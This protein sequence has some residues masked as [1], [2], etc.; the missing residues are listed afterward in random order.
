M[1]IAMKN[2]VRNP[3]FEFPLH[4]NFHL[5]RLCGTASCLLSEGVPAV[6]DFN[7]IPGAL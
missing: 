1:V 4:L 7:L 5:V 3:E 6:R 2:E